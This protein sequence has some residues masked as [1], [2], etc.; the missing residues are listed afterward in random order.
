MTNSKDPNERM[1]NDTLFSA[2]SIP[3]TCGNLIGG[4][5]HAQGEQIPVIDPATEEVISQIHEADAQTVD[6]AVATA[7]KAFDQ[8]AWSRAGMEARQRV[9]NSIADL[10]EQNANELAWLECRDV[11]IPFK[12]ALGRHVLRAAYNFRFFAEY[13]S[14]S[15]SEAYTQLDNYLTLVTREPVG[16]AALIGPWNAPI[17]LTTMKMAGA[18]AFGNSCVVK[19]SE[20]SP[21]TA[22]RVVQ[23]MLEAGLPEGV[24]NLV[25]GHGHVTGAALAAHPGIDLLSFTGGTTTG[26]AIMAAAG[27]N[28]TPVTLELGGKSS[29]IICADADQSRALDGALL[30][31]FSNNGQQ[32]L[33][34]SR[35]LV[36]KDIADDFIGKFVERT[37][38][39]K[40]G[41]PLDAAT[42]IGPLATKAHFDRVRSFV[43]VARDD[44]CTVLHGGNPAKG[45][46]KGYYLEPTVVMA[47]GNK[48]TV[49]QEEIFGPFATFQTFGTIEEAFAI[50]NDTRFG[51]LNYVW[52]ESLQTA[53]SAH[54]SLKSG[55]LCINSPIIRELRAPFGGYKESGVGR[56]GGKACELFYTEQKTSAIP[57]AAMPLNQLGLPQGPTE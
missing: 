39:I 38:N 23:L 46:D 19:P 3:D 10:I 32:C 15:A 48:A 42:E 29:N 33:A 26:R 49:C 43:G 24:V 27:K 6:L 44:G 55:T 8:G 21:L 14:Q 57:L 12:Q 1:L 20:S 25:N 41:H 53:M 22:I 9:L 31:I 17:A 52:T 2:F 35:I 30:G 11:G 37:K 50:A 34:G 18:I 51:L 54:K 45:F 7:R 40:I 28:L 36:Q 13:I 16:V 56:E 47:P 5:W 4:K